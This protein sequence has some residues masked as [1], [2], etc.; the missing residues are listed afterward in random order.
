[1][2]FSSRNYLFLGI[3]LL[4]VLV[5]FTAMYLENEVEGFI[6][7]FISPLLIIAGYGVAAYAVMTHKQEENGNS[8]PSAG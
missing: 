5:G 6:S 4:L 2:L 8:S 3:G 7:L 1:M